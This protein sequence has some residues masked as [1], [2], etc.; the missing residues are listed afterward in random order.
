MTGTT[1]K[2]D[3]R[4]WRLA[5]DVVIRPVT[6]M[7]SETVEQ[8]MQSKKNPENYFGIERKKCRAPAKIVN[9]D[10]VD[11]LKAFGEAG[12]T[13]EDVLEHF[14]EER[15]LKWEELHKGMHAMVRTFISSNFLVEGKR[16]SGDASEAVEPSF[17]EG[18]RWLDYRIV[19][20]VHVIID[21]EIYQVE[22]IPTGETK[23]LK[24]TQRSFPRREMKSKIF[25]RLEHEFRT[26]EKMK[27]PYIVKIYDYGV[28]E[29]RMYGILEW[30]DGRSVYSYA[31]ESGDDAPD[32]GLILRLSVE[33]LEA[34]DA[35]H[36]AR[37]LHGDVHTRNFLV[38]RG[39]V[40]LID[41][42]LSRP[43]EIDEKDAHTYV[44][45]GVVRFM[46]PEYVAY[47]FENRK[48][49]WGSVAGEIYSCGVM[50][51]SLF[52]KTYP[53]KWSFYREDFMKSILNDPPPSFEECERAPRPELEAALQRALEKEPDKR[54]STAGEFAAA[55]Q[56]L[57]FPRGNRGE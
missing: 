12:A 57:S 13:Y 16:A 34:L 40:C 30:I 46:P 39:R 32:D 26:I 19:K 22:H 6:E 23:A 20:N 4:V 28:H 50:I 14:L 33:C 55:L 3:K 15:N 36:T 42:G 35:V 5:S 49:L 41:F 44:E 47:K 51:F 11:V 7:P 56:K 24:I 37:Y 10:V 29:G 9:K 2:K 27:H 1:G 31:Y 52:T 38:N 54:Y 53:Y 21:T 17:R 45:G 25:E 8:V 43:I 18:D 48:G